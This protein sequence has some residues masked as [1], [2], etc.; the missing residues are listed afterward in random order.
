M[1]PAA[2]TC[3]ARPATPCVKTGSCST[4]QS[5]SG[6]ASRARLGEGTHRPRCPHSGRRPKVHDSHAQSL[7][8]HAYPARPCD[9][10]GDALGLPCDPAFARRRCTC[11]RARHAASPARAGSTRLALTKRGDSRRP[12]T[13]FTRLA[14]RRPG[15]RLQPG[16]DAPARRS[17]E[18]EPAAGPALDDARRRGRL[19]DGACSGWRSCMSWASPACRDL[20]QA[21]RWYLRAAEAGSVD[22][23]VAV[24]TAHYL[25][26]G[27][28]KDAAAA[29][30][31]RRGGARRRCRR[32]VPRRVDVRERR[33][34]ASAICSW[35]A[36]GTSAAAG[37]GDEAA[38]SK[39]ERTR[40]QA[41]TRR[42]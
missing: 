30:W 6:V 26:R 14:A 28:P 31:F 13:R 17:A 38:P 32:A 11:R 35:R 5:S 1:P 19:R 7:G 22:G 25:G 29:H 34:R 36:T 10:R 18:P 2:S 33:R 42:K 9:R 16:R 8:R 39:V 24:G 15:R 41:R 3:S 4:S 20:R 37:N 27:A 23:Q 21:N 40:R 12:S